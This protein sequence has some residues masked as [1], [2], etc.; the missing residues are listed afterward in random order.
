MA[1]SDYLLI[2]DFCVGREVKAVIRR[3][4][5]KKALLKD[6]ANFTEQNFKGNL[7]CTTPMNGC[8]RKVV[9]NPFH[10]TGRYSILH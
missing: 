8:F 7:F 5:A 4:S 1:F 6:F 2:T 3:C 9:I 10:A